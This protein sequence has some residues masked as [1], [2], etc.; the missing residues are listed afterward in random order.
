MMVLSGLALSPDMTCCQHPAQFADVLPSR[1]F[2]LTYSPVVSL[3]LPQTDR[4]A[5]LVLASLQLL[6]AEQ[7]KNCRH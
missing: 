3:L 5:Q 1:T 6:H 2:H 7:H 4:P